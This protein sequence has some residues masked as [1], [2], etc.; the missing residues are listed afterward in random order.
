M[1]NITSEPV[2]V[3]NVNVKLR[4]RIVNVDKLQQAKADQYTRRNNVE[5]SGISNEISDEDLEN[6]VIEIYKNSDIIM[7]PANIEICHR[8][9]LGHNNATNNRQV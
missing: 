2:I 3:R 6:N 1:K 7:N 4:N 9:P 5:I 8:L